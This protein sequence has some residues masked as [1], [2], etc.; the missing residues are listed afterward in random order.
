MI[1]MNENAYNYVNLDYLNMMSDGDDSMKKVMLEMLFEELPEEVAK[2]RSLLEA[3]AITELGAVSHKM[4]STLAFVGNGEMTAA[5]KE[6]E[7]LAK[8]GVMSDNFLGLIEKLEE[9]TPLA[10]AELKSEYNSI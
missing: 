9:L 1:T 10:I 4:K 5:N 6:V 8:A 2:M 7:E 3:G